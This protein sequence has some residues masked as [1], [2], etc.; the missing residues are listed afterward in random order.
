MRTTSLLHMRGLG[1]SEPSALMDQMLEPMGDHPP[2]SYSSNF[3]ERMPEDIRIQHKHEE[4][5]RQLAKRADA[6]WTAKD[7]ATTSAVEHKPQCHHPQTRSR[8]ALPISNKKKPVFLSLEVWCSHSEMPRPLWMDGKRVGQP[9]LMAMVAG[10][11]D[12]LL[13]ISDNRSGRRFL[14]DMGTEVSIFS[15]TSLNTRTLPSTLLLAANGSSIKTY[16]IP[17]TPLLAAN[18]SSIRTNGKHMSP[19]S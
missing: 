5:C 9:P 3:M 18:G 1:G 8:V 14:V 2:P 15:A 17:S 6:L 10:P 11:K 4:D 13:Y 12:F 7:T 16:S 19:S